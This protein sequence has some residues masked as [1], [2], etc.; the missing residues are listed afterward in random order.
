V[1]K[2]RRGSLYRFGGAGGRITLAERHNPG[3]SDHGAGLPGDVSA[4]PSRNVRMTP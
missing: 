4:R 3:Q 2:G 1:R